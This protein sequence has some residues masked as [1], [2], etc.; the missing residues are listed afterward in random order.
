MLWIGIWVHPYTVT[1]A[2][3]A[4]NLVIW[5]SVATM[6]WW[7]DD[8]VEA[9][10][11]HWLLPT[12]ILDIWWAPSYAVD[13]YMGAPLHGYTGIVG[14]DFGNLGQRGYYEM[15]A[16]LHCCGCRPPLF[17]SHIH[18]RYVQ[19]VWA[20]SYAVDRHMGAPLHCYIGKVSPDFGNLGQR[21]YYEMMAW[22]H[23]WGCKPPLTAFHI[24]RKCLSTVICCG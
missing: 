10:D 18:I 6:K 8:I 3:L 13:R 19:S 12:S 9:V 20:P 22:L 4:Q 1:L 23:C 15:M 16:W 7:H 5:A 2:K 11:H 21:G 24:H 17:A 14:P